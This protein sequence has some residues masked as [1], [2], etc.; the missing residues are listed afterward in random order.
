M[1]TAANETVLLKTPQGH[2]VLAEFDYVQFEIRRAK[3]V[4]TFTGVTRPVGGDTLDDLSRALHAKQLHEHA[5]WETKALE[6]TLE[7]FGVAL[8]A[9]GEDHPAVMPYWQEVRQHRAIARDMGE[10]A[11]HFHAQAMSAIDKIAGD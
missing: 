4:H 5:L 2:D 6:T 1:P 10:R 9:M 7:S 11:R 3:V 8:A